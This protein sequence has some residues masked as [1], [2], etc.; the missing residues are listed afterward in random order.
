MPDGQVKDQI[1]LRIDGAVSHFLDDYDTFIARSPIGP[2]PPPGPLADPILLWLTA[3]AN[4]AHEG[5]AR[6][7]LL[8][9]AGRLLQKSL[10]SAPHAAATLPSDQEIEVL[11]AFP[12]GN[13]QC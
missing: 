12:P 9:V 1:D 11:T 8:D 13:G 3:A 7:E 4:A 5:R 6:D 2:W 10:A